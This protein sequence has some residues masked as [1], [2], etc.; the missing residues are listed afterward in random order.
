[1]ICSNLQNCIDEQL[2]GKKLKKC[3][4]QNSTDCIESSDTRSAIKCEE[5]GKKYIYE[6]SKKN[7]V[8][9]FKMDGGIIVEDNTVPANTNKCDYLYVI[10]ETELTAVKKKKKGVNVKKS[11]EQISGTL[12]L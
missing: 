3:D 11:L 10:N 12:L 7:H 9:S 2:A 8:I 1:M 4:N 6:N 5:R